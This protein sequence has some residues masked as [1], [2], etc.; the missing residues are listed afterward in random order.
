MGSAALLGGLRCKRASKGSG[1][2]GTPWAMLIS[3][4]SARGSPPILVSTSVSTPTSPGYICTTPHPHPHPHLHPHPH[5]ISVSVLNCISVSICMSIPIS[6]I[7][8][9]LHRVRMVYLGL[10]LC[11]S[12]SRISISICISVSILMPSSKHVCLLITCVGISTHIHTCTSL[13]VY[14]CITPDLPL[15]FTSVL[16]FSAVSAPPLPICLPPPR[17]RQSCLPSIAAR[18]GLVSDFYNCWGSF[19]F[20]IQEKHP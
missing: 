12:T 9:C 15:T 10:H 5:H 20:P 7:D 18:P 19:A 2:A 11:P 14:T 4:G 8:V 17:G 6:G 3:D 16:S 1:D 13:C